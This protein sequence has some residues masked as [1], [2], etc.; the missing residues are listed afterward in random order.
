MNA[1]SEYPRG[2]NS[3]CVVRSR[4]G[5]ALLV[6]TAAAWTLSGCAIFT[7]PAPHAHGPTVPSGRYDSGAEKWADESAAARRKAEKEKTAKVLDKIERP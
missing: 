7:P 1:F 4:L 3:R 5:K 6:V 2:C